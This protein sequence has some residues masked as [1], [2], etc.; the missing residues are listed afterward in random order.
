MFLGTQT[1]DNRYLTPVYFQFHG[2][3]MTCTE[4]IRIREKERKREKN[5]LKRSVE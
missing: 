5:S 3:F 4:K 1:R 2:Y